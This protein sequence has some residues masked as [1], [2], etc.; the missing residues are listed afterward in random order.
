MPSA[1]VDK[2]GPPG[3]DHQ[4]SG[5]KTRPLE[6]AIDKMNT[7]L[8]FSLHACLVDE[9]NFETYCNGNYILSPSK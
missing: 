1:G 7:L 6:T 9:A 4:I 8:C 5:V 3:L 2:S